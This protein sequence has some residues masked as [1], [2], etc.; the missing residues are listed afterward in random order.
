LV[1]DQEVAGRPYRTPGQ[2]VLRLPPSAAYGHRSRRGRSVG[3][4]KIAVHNGYTGGQQHVQPP[5]T[6]RQ[7]PR[8]CGFDA[9]G[10][11]NG[12]RRI[13]CCSRIGLLRPRNS[14]EAEPGRRT[15]FRIA[16]T[17]AQQIGHDPNDPAEILRVLPPDC[18]GSFLAE[19]SEA[20]YRARRPEEYRALTELLHLWRLRAV[21]YSEPG[22]VAR[23]ATARAGDWAGVVPLEELIADRPSG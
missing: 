4:I 14:C 18:H 2:Q 10:R 23:L 16:S 8:P 22:Y 20:L 15:G 5:W 13:G 1:R 17:T 21:A 9:L 12:S 3:Q 11:R 7:R 6:T 19:Y